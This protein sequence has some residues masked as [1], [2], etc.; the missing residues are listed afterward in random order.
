MVDSKFQYIHHFVSSKEIANAVKED[1]VNREDCKH[2]D[3]I[4]AEEH[5]GTARWDPGGSLWV[6]DKTHV[7]SL[8]NIDIEVYLQHVNAFVIWANRAKEKLRDWH[9]VKYHKIHSG[10]LFCIC[11]SPDE[12]DELINQLNNPEL[13]FK[14][15]TS[16]EERNE[17]MSAAGILKAVK[18]KDSDGNEKVIVIKPKKPTLN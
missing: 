12:L 10:Y 13:A 16:E 3:I 6:G 2:P 4:T 14:A 15:S 5:D 9:G 1:L 18:I 8:T 11:I 7:F 17:R